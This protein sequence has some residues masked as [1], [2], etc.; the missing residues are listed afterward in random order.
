MLETVL[1]TAVIY[2]FVIFAV[3]LMGKRQISDMQP[4][5]LVITILLSEIAA[6]PLQDI[7]QP[8]TNGVLAIFILA[9][10]EVIMSVLALK[11]RKIRTMLSGKPII[12]INNSVIDQKALKK[13]RMSVHD[14]TE[15]L[16]GKDVFDISQ[17]AYAIL[18]V[19][20]ELNVLL[21]KEYEKV[22]LSDIN[23]KAKKAALP[24]TVVC[25]GAICK[26]S[27]DNLKLSED[28]VL[29]ILRSKHKKLED[30]FLMSLDSL[31]NS[32]II[33]K[34]GGK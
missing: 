31:G 19:N 8:F 16:R 4:N 26:D 24:L 14:L 12:I 25:D 34:E 11:S 28:D 3:R 6:I 21:K 32:T 22:T 27:L 1:R 13:V 23:I 15:L 33:D 7:S 20:G 29:K 30:V 10:L 18:E 5:E 17:V 2:F 9:V